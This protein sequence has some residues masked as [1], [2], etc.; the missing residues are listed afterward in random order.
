MA[1]EAPTLAPTSTA[2]TEDLNHIGTIRILGLTLAVIVAGFTIY[3][4][5]WVQTHR[6]VRVVKVHQPLFLTTLFVGLVVWDLSVIPSSIDDGVASERGCDIACLWWVWLFNMGYAI[7]YAAMFAKLRRVNKLFQNPQFRRIKVE[8][9]DVLGPFAVLVFLVF[10]LMLCWTLL[11]PPRWERKH[12]EEN[13][14]WNTYGSCTN[15]GAAGQAL[16]ICIIVVHYSALLLV[17]WEAWKA[18]QISDE[19]SESKKIAIIVFNWL[20]LELIATP[21]FYLSGNENTRVRYWV[22]T[23]A[24]LAE[25]MSVLFVLFVPIFL[26]HRR[27]RLQGN[28]GSTIRISGLQEGVY[29]Q[30]G[31]TNKSSRSVLQDSGD[32]NAGKTQLAAVPEDNPDPWQRITELEQKIEQL[33]RRENDET[34]ERNVSFLVDNSTDNLEPTGED[35]DKELQNG[36]HES[37]DPEA[38]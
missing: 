29:Q 8:A 22:L 7:S 28:N 18:R 6:Q 9:K 35:S 3:G 14:E 38:D 26:H 31:M 15:S 4:I 1:D 37:R 33:Q 16:P 19:F 24:L 5:I 36:Q 20:Q 12:V 25:S 21:V 2:P 11:D 27:F 10:T 32:T 13:N 34:G 17:C 30:S 23:S